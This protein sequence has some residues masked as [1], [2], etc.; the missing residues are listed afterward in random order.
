MKFDYVTGNPPYQLETTNVSLS[1]GQLR[2]KS[3]FHYFQIEADKIANESTVLIYPAGRWIQRSGKGMAAFGME[4]INDHKLS[5]IYFYPDSKEVFP[6][7][8]IADGVS[9]VVKNMK[10]D[11]PGFDYVY[12][13]N[14]KENHIAMDNPGENII[15]LNPQDISISKKLE[16]F[17]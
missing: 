14:G 11:S 15:P 17:I 3:I 13:K 7:A 16:A 10:K 12:C 9:V 4:Q 1:N 2:S 5:E 6:N 8:A